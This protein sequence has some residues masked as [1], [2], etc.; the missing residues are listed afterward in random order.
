M[1]EEVLPLLL[2]N[3]VLVDVGAWLCLMGSSVCASHMI[4]QRI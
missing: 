2:I 3:Q 1:G 4:S